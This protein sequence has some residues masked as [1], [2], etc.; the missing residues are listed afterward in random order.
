MNVIAR[1][2]V[3]IESV[4]GPEGTRY[5]GIGDMQTQLFI[6]PAKSGSFVWGVGPTFSFPTATT[7]TAETGT[8]AMGPSA[9]VVKM[10]G[11]WVVGS[12]ISQ[13]WPLHDAAG[14]P[15]TDLFTLQPFINYNFGQG[16]ALAFAPIITANWN[17][18]DDNQWTVPLGFGISKTAIFNSRP[19]SLGAQYYYN[20]ER[21]DGA[22]GQQLRFLVSFLFP[23]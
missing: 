17:A 19:V 15:E 21:P 10:A 13:L 8:W 5:S 1:F 12:L 23:R 2:I 20:I 6:T 11:P 16:W 9:V 3:P 14:D 22:P 18:A 4:P 7:A